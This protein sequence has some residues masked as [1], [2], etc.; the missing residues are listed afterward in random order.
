MTPAR[1]TWSSAM[2]PGATSAHRGPRATT[3]FW[4]RQ[5]VDALAPASQ[6]RASHRPAPPMQRRRPGRGDRPARAQRPR[7]GPPAGRHRRAPRSAR[8]APRS[9]CSRSWTTARSG[10]SRRSDRRSGRSPSSSR[11]ASTPSRPPTGWSCP[12]PPTTAFSASALVTGPAALR[13]YAGYP[14]EAP[15]GTRIG[16]LCVF[17][18]SPREQ[19]EG[20]AD[21]DVLRELALL[22]QRELWRWAPARTDR[23]TVGGSSAVSRRSSEP[24]RPQRSERAPRASRCSALGGVRRASTVGSGEVAD[25]LDDRRRHGEVVA[26]GGEAGAGRRLHAARGIFGGGDDPAQ[27]SVVG[28]QRGCGLLADAGDARAGRR[29]SPRAWPR[30]RR[31]GRR[32]RRTS[33]ARPPPVTHLQVAHAASGIDDA[34]V[35]LVVDELEQVA[36]A[37]HHIHRSVGAGRQRSDHVVRLGESRADDRDADGVEHLPD[38]RHLRDQRFGSLLDVHATRHDLRHPV[39]LVARDE[40]DPPPRAPVV[41]PAGDQRVGTVVGH[42]LGDDVEEAAHGVDRGAVGRLHRVRDAVE[43]AEVEGGAVEQ[44]RSACHVPILARRELRR[45]G[46][47]LAWRCDR[48]S[49]DRLR[50]RR[51]PRPQ[52][53]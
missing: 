4:A 11:C 50:R 28:E 24:P 18:R 37:G 20:E 46:L 35:P 47:P 51:H 32:G 43:R 34:H 10:R 36:V 22:A 45:N 5:I 9:R 38:H 48:R 33:G 31:I 27:V 52:Q 39:R 26:G 21:L 42:E 44:H 13:Y 2:R 30:S 53:C 25:D 14:V 12:T 16:A 6:E 15:D 7:R 41:V 19:S 40:V 23:A 1:S 3:C 49:A 8:S 17:G 29:R